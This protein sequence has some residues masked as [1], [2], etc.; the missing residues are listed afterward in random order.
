MGDWYRSTRSLEVK[1]FV[2]KKMKKS[3][4]SSSSGK[5]IGGFVGV[6]RF[7]SNGVGQ[8]VSALNIDLQI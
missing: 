5:V 4:R 2:L 8:N 1:E 3:F 7:K 6:T